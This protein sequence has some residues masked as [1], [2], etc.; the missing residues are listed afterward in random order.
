MESID[1][2]LALLGNVIDDIYA[3][4][5]HAHDKYRSYPPEFLL[6]HDPRAAAAC[7]YCHMA[8]EAERRWID[9]AGVVPVDIRGLKVWLIGSGAVLRFKKMDE[10]GRAR[11]YPTRQARAYD[12]G[13]AFQELPPPAV[14]L[15]AGYLLNPTGTEIT[16][17]QIAKP[18]GGGVQWCVAI[19]PPGAAVRWEVVHRRFGTG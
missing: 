12:R 1:D 8:A 2:V 13:S 7:T 5:H 11:T 10:E 3:I 9:R 6:D 14:R 18:D 4:P 19:N 15:T 17:V 16:R